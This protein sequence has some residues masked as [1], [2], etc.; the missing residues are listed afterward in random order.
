[1]GKLLLGALLPLLC[2]LEIASSDN[3][4]L[5]REV[6]IIRDG[7]WWCY[8]HPEI[9]EIP[10]SDVK[11]TAILSKE[12]TDALNNA[13]KI[14]G[15][16]LS[17]PIGSILNDLLKARKF[18]LLNNSTNDP[19]P[20]TFTAVKPIIT[21]ILKNGERLNPKQK[22][23]STTTDDLLLQTVELNLVCSP[24]SKQKGRR[25]SEGRMHIL[26]TTSFRYPINTFSILLVIYI[27]LWLICLNIIRKLWH[28]F[29]K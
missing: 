13:I 14:P 3:N 24:D 17:I 26:Q 23:C 20:K 12:L 9:L 7:K 28:Y 10:I 27:I 16:P 1:M 8:E 11:E 25:I 6:P 2:L 29:I 19:D 21:L 4:I 22:F 18:C 5:E 15:I